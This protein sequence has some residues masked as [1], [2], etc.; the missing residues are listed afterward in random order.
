MFSLKETKTL[1]KKIQIK[2]PNIRSFR[3]YSDTRKNVILR[4]TSSPQGISGT[5]R[6]P[7]GFVFLQPLKD[8][9]TEHIFYRSNKYNYIE[10]KLF[11]KTNSIK[12]GST[13]KKTKQN[14]SVQKIINK[15]F[16]N[17]DKILNYTRKQTSKMRRLRDMNVL[18]FNHPEFLKA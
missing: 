10:E 6:T 15:N 14:A 17:P 13:I 16:D 4:I 11:C 3:G 18:L 1:S 8:S 7:K 5:L 2:Y 9:N 12:I